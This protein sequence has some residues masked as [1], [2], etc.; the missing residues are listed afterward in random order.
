MRKRKASETRFL[1]IFDGF[2]R[3]LGPQTEA[4]RSKINVERASKFDPFLKASW[5]TIFSAQ[6]APRDENPRKVESARRN[7]QP[8]GEGLGEGSRRMMSGTWL[9]KDLEGQEDLDS[10]VQHAFPSWATDRFAHSAGPC[11]VEG[12]R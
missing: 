1:S 4:R 9:W 6:D 5:N 7:V 12:L 2:V 3:H 11:H 8:L 10:K